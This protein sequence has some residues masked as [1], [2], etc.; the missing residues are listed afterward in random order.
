MRRLHFVVLTLLGT[1]LA[2]VPVLAAP[3]QLTA[4]PP[5]VP[6]GSPITFKGDGFDPAVTYRLEVVEPSGKVNFAGSVASTEIGA[7]GTLRIDGGFEGTDPTGQWTVRILD[8]SGRVVASATFTLTDRS[9]AGGVV[10]TASATPNATGTGGA[11]TPATLPATGHPAAASLSA[12]KALGIGAVAVTLGI[13]L[14]LHRRR[15]AVPS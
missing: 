6:Q 10:P 11:T 8:A 14:R 15:H 4:S 2:A 1:M 9:A 12:A 7:D 5:S 13:A 3:P